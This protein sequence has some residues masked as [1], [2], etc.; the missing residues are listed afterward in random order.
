MHPICFAHEGLESRE[1]KKKHPYE[2]I[3]RT[4]KKIEIQT[5]GRPAGNAPMTL[6]L[7]RKALLSSVQSLQ[8]NKGRAWTSLAFMAK[9]LLR[10]SSCGNV[11]NKPHTV[12]RKEFFKHDREFDKCGMGPK[13]CTCSDSLQQASHM[14]LV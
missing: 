10:A 2:R 13:S 11:P 14:H 7:S 4:A 9:V 3:Q 1:K 5:H 12:W 6:Q 8:T